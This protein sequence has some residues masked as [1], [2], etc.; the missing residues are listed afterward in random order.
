M[1]SLRHVDGERWQVSL[2]AGRDA[3]GKERR[4]TRNFTAKG[5]QEARRRAGQ[6]ESTLRLRSP[7]RGVT[8][9]A[10]LVDRW[11]AHRESMPTASPT[12]IGRQRYITD[13]IK[14]D[15]GK[16]RLDKLEPVQID[17]WYGRLRGTKTGRGQRSESTVHHYHRVLKAIIRQGHKWGYVDKSVIERVTPPAPRRRPI[18]PPTSDDVNKVLAAAGG[19]FDVLLRLYATTGARRSEVLGLRWGD[20]E[21]EHLVFRRT[22]VEVNK[23]PLMVKE[24]LKNPDEPP[25]LVLLDAATLEM[26]T[27]YRERVAVT[28]RDLGSRIGDGVYIFPD[29][30]ADPTGRTPR[31]P[32][33]VSHRFADVCRSA[34][35]T[36][37]LHDLRHWH[38]TQLLAAGVPITDVADRLGH[39]QTS[40]TLN[41][42]AH[43]TRTHER[44]AADAIG[45]ALDGQ[46]PD[47]PTATAARSRLR[48]P[49]R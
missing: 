32:N 48:G 35:V 45:R 27:E 38:A 20:L 25:R 2:Y 7:S 47:T 26:L 11:T 28:L 9:M 4:V 29:L 49:R 22:V 44:A 1:A 17:E 21:G 15:L 18:K 23:K 43:G 37:R 10:E 46:R 42:Y 24:W 40:T 16:L 31:R 34:K 33:T 3:N 5:I 8:T 12:T 13:R 6:I 41:I 19:D 14:A 30:A 39:S 36:M